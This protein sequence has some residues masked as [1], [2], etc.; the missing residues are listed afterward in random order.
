MKKK[1]DKIQ[2]IYEVIRNEIE[3]ISGNNNS[4]DKNIGYEIIRRSNTN[5]TDTL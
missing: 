5:F 2:K 4:I 1:F 3:I